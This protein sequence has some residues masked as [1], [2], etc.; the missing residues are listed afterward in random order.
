[1]EYQAFSHIIGG[2]LIFGL[3][4]RFFPH[5]ACLFLWVTEDSMDL[6][7]ATIVSECSL[8]GEEKSLM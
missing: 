1:M 7:M 3:F 6:A 2:V 5:F 4:E 8:Q